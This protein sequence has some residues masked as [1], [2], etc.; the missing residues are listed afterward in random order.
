MTEMEINNNVDEIITKANT[1]IEA[2]P[3]IRRFNGA[4]IIVSMVVV[5]CLMIS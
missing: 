3:Y 1:L 4:T 5:P 2:L